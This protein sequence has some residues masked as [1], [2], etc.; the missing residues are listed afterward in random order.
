MAGL[1]DA[2]GEFKLSQSVPSIR[3]MRE[4]LTRM[5]G[6]LTVCDDADI[7]HCVDL[8][9]TPDDD[10]PPDEWSYTETGW[11]MYQ[12]KY[13]H[14]RSAANELGNRII[15]VVKGHPVLRS[16][17]RVC[18]MPTS[19]SGKHFDAPRVWKSMIVKELNIEPLK[20]SRTRP[21]V[22]QKAIESVEEKA[23]N[24]E[25]SMEAPNVDGKTVLVLDDLYMSGRTMKE[26]VRALCEAGAGETFALCAVKTAT[27]TRGGAQSLILNTDDH[28]DTR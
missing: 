6:L 18:A 17:D 16:A 11:L 25:G 19:G 10:L 3:S 7:S 23:R 15:E 8:Y 12:A 20:L 1:L 22:Q 27:G 4:I 21:V 14:N 24:Q 26:A 9:R 5:K 28:G 2:R 13:Q